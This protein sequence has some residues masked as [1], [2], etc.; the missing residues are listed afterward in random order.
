[1]KVLASYSIKGGVGKTA[2]AVNLAYEAARSGERTLLWDL[3]PQGA[4][5]H[6]LRVRARVKGGGRALVSGRVSLAERTKGTDFDGLDLLP[7][8]FSYRHLDL[9]LD[10][11]SHSV[12]RLAR[13]LAPASAEYDWII[14]DCAPG[15]SLASEAVFAAADALVVPVIPTT[16]S[17]RT[18]DQLAA[19]LAETPGSP[20]LLGFLSMVDRRKRLH[21][22]TIAGLSLSAHT[23]LPTQIVT[24]SE[25]EKMGLY[26]A[27]VGAYAP[28]S[29]S[30]AAYRELWRDIRARL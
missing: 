11:A 14:L 6:Y 1:M 5:T 17:V 16:L 23:V 7:A 13:L 9:E 29:A 18:L 15:I 10:G 28:D 19:F 20:Q 2:A 12:Q 26:R 4:A 8:D 21:S 30:A 25:V 3:D 24:C 22:E 27:P